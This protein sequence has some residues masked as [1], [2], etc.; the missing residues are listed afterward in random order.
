MRP[1]PASTAAIG[2]IAVK[3]LKIST[4]ALLSVLALAACD[5]DGG[6]GPGGPP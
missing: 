6:T 3:T 2:R 5:D 4:L 1:V